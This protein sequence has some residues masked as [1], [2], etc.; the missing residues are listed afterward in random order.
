M[1]VPFANGRW[2]IDFISDL[3]TTADASATGWLTIAR[4]T[5]CAGGRDTSLSG[6]LVVRELNRR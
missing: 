4:A 6:A 1:T 3:L 5:A 2:S